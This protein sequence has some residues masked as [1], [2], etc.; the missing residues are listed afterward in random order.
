MSH[1]EWIPP[2]SG[3]TP[4]RSAWRLFPWL[5]AAGMGIVV[6]VN[7]GMIYA[8]LASFPG[9]ASDGDF[10]LSNRYDAVLDAAQREAALGWDLQ[11][12]TDDTGRAVVVLLDRNGS[13][14]RGATLAGAAT[15]PLGAL[16]TQ[17]LVFQETVA[18]SYE[19]NM[20]LPA[21]G[22][23]ELSLSASADGHD[24]EMT[25]RVIVR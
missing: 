22:Q 1:I 11:A 19:A 12:R 4:P 9:K 17:P 16:E 10:A 8:A 14:L 24:M 18:G 5:V 23:W 21:R 2:P 7:A 15:R 6:A 20:A 25:R 3:R 13:P